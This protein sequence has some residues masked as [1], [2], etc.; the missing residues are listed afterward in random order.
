MQ[1][2]ARWTTETYVRCVV[3]SQIRA[4][5]QLLATWSLT[6]QPSSDLQGTLASP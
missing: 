2:N 3:P 1:T 4:L 5:Q 6:D